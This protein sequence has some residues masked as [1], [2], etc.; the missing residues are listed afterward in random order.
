[1]RGKLFFIPGIVWHITQRCHNQDFLLKFIKDK[2]RWLHWLFQAKLKYG[3]NILNYAV[4]SNHI[5]L[6]VF[7]DGCR[8]TIPRSIQL[9]ASRTAIEF[10]LRKNR[11]GAFWDDNYHATAVENDHHLHQ[12]MVYIDLNMVRAG[13]VDHP[14]EWAFCGYNELMQNPQRYRLINIKKV[15]ELTGTTDRITFKKFYSERVE[16]TLLS[17]QMERDIRWTESIA[18][19]SKTFINNV[20]NRLGYKV[21]YRNVKIINKSWIIK[22]G[23]S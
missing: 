4:T 6:L 10:N 20:R 2:K 3:L 7:A 23:F 15:M 17:D 19:G 1:M 14:S 18:V 8:Q 16:S 5:H 21:Q 11:S 12:C 13:V 22:D 9:I